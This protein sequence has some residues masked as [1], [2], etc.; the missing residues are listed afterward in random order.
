MLGIKSIFF[1]YNNEQITIT[2]QEENSINYKGI[3]AEL[4]NEKTFKYIEHLFRIIDSWQPNYIDNSTTDNIT[5]K[6][7]ITYQDNHTKEYKGKAHFP[8]NFEALIRLN[9]ELISEVF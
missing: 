2:I 9:K 1:E 4:N 6:L 8:N 5:W 3:K 7:T